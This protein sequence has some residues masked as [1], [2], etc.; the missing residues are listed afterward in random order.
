MNI[1]EF[2]RHADRDGLI[3]ISPEWGL[4]YRLVS[5]PSTFVEWLRHLDGKSR[6]VAEKLAI[7]PELVEYAARSTAA[8]TPDEIRELNREVAA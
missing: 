1:N 4:F 2:L 8:L 3:G 7:H 6:V 5:T